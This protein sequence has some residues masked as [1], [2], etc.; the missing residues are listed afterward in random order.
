M[1]LRNLTA[2]E[3]PELIDH[4][5]M[6]F[7]GAPRELF[8]RAYGANPTSD[9]S[10]TKVIIEDGRI[11]SA[12]R[13]LSKPVRIGS[14]RVE[15]GG[16]GGV[17]THPD[18]RGRGH[19]TALLN[20]HLEEMER[21]EYDISML[22]TGLTGFYGRLGY[23]PFPEHSCSIVLPE[24]VEQVDSP[25]TIRSCDYGADVDALMAC[26]DQFNA[27]RTLSMVREP[28]HWQRDARYDYGD[29]MPWLVAEA[30][31][32]VVAYISGSPKRVHEACC[33]N[34][35]LQAFV[36]LARAAMAAALAEQ[37][38]ES[39][40]CNL[41][42]AH[43]FVDEMRRLS[44][45]RISHTLGE[46]MM[47]RVIR[48]QPLF[49]KLLV[50]FNLRLQ[51]AGLAVAQPLT[52]GFEQAGQRVTL[53]VHGPEARVC[54][55]E[56]DFTLDVSGREFFLLLCGAATIDELDDILA[57]RGVRIPEQYHQLLRALFPRQ[58]PVF[59]ASDHF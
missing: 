27:S 40:A 18:Y 49:E 14:T 39:I 13:V 56:P 33:C 43:P 48:L 54:A 47:L 24:A 21:R 46:G 45:T 1:E 8:E 4:L 9:P 58:D 31:G 15:M 2:D 20:A 51:R 25:Y 35:H 11:V 36:A 29:A 55:S 41:P 23:E 32:R 3:I 42:F 44:P 6:V 10:Q 52:L 12:V 34:G 19:S 59:Y 28:I 22:F 57:L 7:E 17:S 38:V 50:E 5:D 53:C 16:V 37:G 26:Y 30:D